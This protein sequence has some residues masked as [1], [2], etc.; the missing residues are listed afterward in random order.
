MTDD[1]QRAALSYSMGVLAS[2]AEHADSRNV[3]VA[4]LSAYRMLRGIAVDWGMD[5]PD[6][7]EHVDSGDT[8]I[9]P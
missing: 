3:R 2:F 5:L 9:V 7:H 6:L 1:E 4:A 8:R